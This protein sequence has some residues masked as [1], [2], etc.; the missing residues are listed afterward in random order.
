MLLGAVELKRL[1]LLV[2]SSNRDGRALQCFD[3]QNAEGD[4]SL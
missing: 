4:A 3:A 1:L 2:V